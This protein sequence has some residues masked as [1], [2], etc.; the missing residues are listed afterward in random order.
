MPDARGRTPDAP[1]GTRT[2][3]A[4]KRAKPL[5]RAAG[6][7]VAR[8]CRM[9]QDSD[10]ERPRERLRNLGGER[11]SDQ[12]LLA[13]VL[14]T[15]RR[16]RDAR[17]LAGD[18]LAAAGGLGSLA[19]ASPRELEQIGGIGEARALR[20]TAAFHLGRRAIDLVRAAAPTIISPADVW[21]RLRGRVAG[22]PQEV[23]FVVGI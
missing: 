7:G 13:V 5:G 23:F 9:E 6:A 21:W 8:G 1:A 15:G 17:A 20:I 18:I 12:E 2:R 3:A 4:S 11:V 22:L 16:G 14:G 19:R 10:A